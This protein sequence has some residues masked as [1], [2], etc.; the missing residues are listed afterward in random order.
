[1]AKRPNPELV[2]YIERHLTKGF[3]IHHI[4]RKLAEVG[5][6]IEAIEDAAQFVFAKQPKKRAPKFMIVYGIILILVIAA[7][8]W[9]IWFKATQQV[10]YT[11]MVEEIK[12]NVSFSGMT[13]VELMKF[14]AANDDLRACEFIRD[15]NMYYACV[16]KYWTRGD[17][18]FERFT[19]EWDACNSERALSSFDDSFCSKLEDLDGYESCRQA[20]FERVVVL[21]EPEKCVTD[22]CLNYY[23]S[24]DNASVDRDFCS[25]LKFSDW[26]DDCLVFIAVRENDESYCDGFSDINSLFECRSHFIKTLQDA[27]LLCEEINPEGEEEEGQD[28]SIARCFYTLTLKFSL[29]GMPCQQI[30]DFIRGTNDRALLTNYISVYKASH[31]RPEELEGYA[32]KDFLECDM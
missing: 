32:G 4:K 24:M 12:K 1:M 10:E 6:P 19:G 2:R 17:C 11:K 20:V 18:S 8:G 28:F 3:K 15:H 7:A 9:F 13:Y 30:F 25:M 16:D 22:D 29:E 26:R 5:H 14:A 31:D 23:F 27:L 21:N